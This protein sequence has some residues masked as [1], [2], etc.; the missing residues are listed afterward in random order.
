MTTTYGTYDADFNPASITD[1]DNKTTYY[2]YHSYTDANGGTRYLNR[3]KKIKY[4]NGDSLLYYYSPYASNARFFLVDSSRDELNRKTNYFYNTQGNL[5][6]TQ[7]YQRIL[8][9]G[10]A[11]TPQNVNTKFTHNI[12][13][14]LTEVRD[15]ELHR[16]YFHYIPNDTGAYLTESRIDIGNNGEDNQDLVTQYRF[17]ANRGT[18]DTLIYYHD[19]PAN[20]IKVNYYYDLLARLYKIAY[21]DNTNEE[22]VYDKRGNFLE[23]KITKTGTAYYKIQY[24]YDARNHL[25]KV[26][27]FKDLVNYPTTY[28]S[29]LYVYNL[30]DGLTEFSNANDGATNTTILYDYVANRLY[31]TRYA[32]N[33]KD[34][35]GYY[36]SGYLKFKKDRRGEVI[37][38]KYDD[39]WRLTKKRYFD[40]WTS[41]PNSPTDSVV[42]LA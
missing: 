27:E 12:K 16:N 1:P 36:F 15:P 35:L 29:T 32:D 28:D 23:K 30:N 33:N 3:P 11:G 42:F 41:Y 26:K 39:R 31:R 8:A 37:E 34:S 9:D 5:D 13:G 24:E 7:Y 40:D 22:Y 2:T 6:S 10:G 14:N 38:Y 21:P 18:L 19:F 17:N 4:A 25:K 20:P